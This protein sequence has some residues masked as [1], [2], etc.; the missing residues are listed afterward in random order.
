MKVTYI[1]IQLTFFYGTEGYLADLYGCVMHYVLYYQ[2][3]GCYVV[4]PTCLDI[5]TSYDCSDV[6]TYWIL[7][8]HWECS[9]EGSSPFKSNWFLTQFL[10]L[11]L[12]K[13][14]HEYW[15]TDFL[16][17]FEQIL[18]RFAWYYRKLVRPL[19]FL[20]FL[21]QW[22]FVFPPFI[23]IFYFMINK[24]CTFKINSFCVYSELP[25]INRFR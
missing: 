20:F 18:K 19:F 6:R 12:L 2:R 4:L 10:I 25:Y 11:L 24:Q 22:M 15:E 21:T 9:V 14:R 7:S 16:L 3:R 8:I 1:C 13:Y 23:N 17:S 5:S